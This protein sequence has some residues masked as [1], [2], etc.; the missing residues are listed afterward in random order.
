MSEENIQM[1]EQDVVEATPAAKQDE[2]PA[3]VRVESAAQ[4]IKE[5]K[6]PE[7]SQ[8]QTSAVAK[9]DETRLIPARPVA[10]P[11][12]RPAVSRLLVV[13]SR[14]VSPSATCAARFSSSR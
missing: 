6:A 7:D 9:K 10:S 3:E 2:A 14:I 8:T 13:V 5:E 4:E 11:R 1:Q 12:R